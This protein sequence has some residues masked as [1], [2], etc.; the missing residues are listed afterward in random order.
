MFKY[1]LYSCSY[2]ARIILPIPATHFEKTTFL[3]GPIYMEDP[4]RM[5]CPGRF[6]LVESVA[7]VFKKEL[8]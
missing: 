5:L 2:L 1:S 4:V 8:K 3:S 7:R 6:I